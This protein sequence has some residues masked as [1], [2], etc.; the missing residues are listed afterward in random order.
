M[1]GFRGCDYHEK[2]DHRWVRILWA[3]INATLFR[4]T[5]TNVLRIAW[6][7]LFG[8]DLRWNHIIYPSVKIFAP[9]NLSISTGSVIGPGVE[10]YNKAQ[11][12]IGTGVVIS[13]DSYLCTAS[14]DVSS[15]TMDLVAQPINIEDNVWIGS[16]AIVLLG[17]VLHKASVVGAGSVVAKDVDEWSVVV[18]NPAR[19]I[20]KRHLKEELVVG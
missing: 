16:R 12:R 13:Q 8:A 20:K 10:I 4:I 5:P 15:P 18:G 2:K 7:K 1:N 17:V 6:L 11:I 19:V 3:L 14:H 9:W